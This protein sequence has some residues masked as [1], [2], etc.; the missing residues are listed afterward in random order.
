VKIIVTAFRGVPRRSESRQWRG[1]MSS[2]R[3]TLRYDV[4]ENVGDVFVDF[5]LRAHADDL[6]AFSY[7][8]VHGGCMSNDKTVL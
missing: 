1:G 7:T 3:A 6:Q 8:V 5:L 2:Q 4:T